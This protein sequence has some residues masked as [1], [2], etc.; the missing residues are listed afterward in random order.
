VRRHTRRAKIEELAEELT[1]GAAMR[2]RCD[3]TE[4]H[5]VVRAVVDYLV[6]EYPSQDLYIPASVTYPVADIQRDVQGGMSV[7]RVCRK[8]RLD[9]RTLYRLLEEESQ[10]R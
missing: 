8:Y 7:R 1:V 5:K 2:L 6:Q 10:A 9:R 3:G 4:I